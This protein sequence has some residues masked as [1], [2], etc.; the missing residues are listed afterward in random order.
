MITNL[1]Y[2]ALIKEV[3]LTPKP[4][5]VDKNN[6]GS[7]QD[8]NIETF[9]KSAQAI[10]PYIQKFLTCKSDFDALRE[11][12]K[13][14]EKAMFQATKGVNTH[15]GMIF[16]IAIICGAVGSVGCD[17]L[18]KLQKEIRFICKDLITRDLK[19]IKEPT[20]HGERFY[21]QTK[22]AGIRAEAMAGY[23]S[24]FEKSL[25]FFTQQL[26]QHTE[27]EALKLTL[28]LLMSETP[29]SNL[30]ARGG[31][32]G[33]LFVQKESKKLLA[34]EDTLLLDARL[35]KFDDILIRKN[36]SPGG[37]ADLLGL[38]YLLYTFKLLTLN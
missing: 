5:L 14:C 35:K 25:P 4:G 10:K 6:N 12:G 34:L 20:T 17:D 15:K 16:S 32:E 22:L 2:K 23:P 8:M 38:T 33:L 29:D 13:E 18:S 37:S 3:E 19:D 9:Y 21:I 11:V 31:M 1:V 28:L 27:E 24:I 7:H 36:L 26:E 30:F